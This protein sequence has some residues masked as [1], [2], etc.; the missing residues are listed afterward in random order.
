MTHPSVTLL[1]AHAA[2]DAEPEVAEH[3]K[4]CDRCQRYHASLAEAKARFLAAEPAEAFLRRPAIRA[5]LSDPRPEDQPAAPLTAAVE[6]VRRGSWRETG[7]RWLA[8]ASVAAAAAFAGLVIVPSSR[9][10][11]DDIRAKGSMPAARLTVAR[12]RGPSVS[13]HFGQVSIRPGDEL[14]L[15]LD[16]V[17]PMTMSVGILAD[18]GE[19]TLLAPSRRW[20]AGRHDVGGFALQVDHAPTAGWFVAGSRDGMERLRRVGRPGPDVFSCRIEPERRP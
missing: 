15:E 5:A 6:A 8:F 19:F 1:E 4:Q 13:H 11:A 18:D 2:G 17:R 20:A 10:P 16:L 14:Q 9:P 12:K 3:V 7:R